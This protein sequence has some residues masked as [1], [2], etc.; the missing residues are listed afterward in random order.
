MPHIVSI[1]YSSPTEIP[2]PANHYHRVPATTAKLIADRGIENDR[3]SKGGNR[4]VNIM[5]AETLARLADEGFRTA[6][7]QMGEQIVVEGVDADNLREGTRLR[8]GASAIVVVGL[9][10]TPCD[11][12]ERIQG[13]HKKLVRGRLGV[14]ARVISDGTISVGDP[15]AIEPV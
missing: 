10:R 4:Q 8:L 2:R 12:F 13:K 6:P 5:A 3:K 11:R 15:V 1:A 9:A 14:I 7:G